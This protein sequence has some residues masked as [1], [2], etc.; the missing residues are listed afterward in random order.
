MCIFSIVLGKKYQMPHGS[1]NLEKF[2]LSCVL[3]HLKTQNSLK[4]PHSFRVDF[5]IY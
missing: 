2:T 5:F 4:G 3:D 1:G